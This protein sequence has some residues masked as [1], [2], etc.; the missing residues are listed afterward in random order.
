M[1]RLYRVTLT[2]AVADLFLDGQGLL[3][4]GQRLLPI[5]QAVVDLTDVVE[6]GAVFARSPTS[7]VMARAC[8]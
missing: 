1:A 8:W 7:S 3:V 4:I 6:G 5:A 2:R